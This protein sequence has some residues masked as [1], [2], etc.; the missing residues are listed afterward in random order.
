MKYI[1][2]IIS[3]FD[4]TTG[5]LSKHQVGMIGQG[6]KQTFEISSIMKTMID[7]TIPVSRRK[8]ISKPAH[9]PSV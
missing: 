6:L 3:K 9:S 8:Y 1:Q 4:E 2:K 7:S 5:N